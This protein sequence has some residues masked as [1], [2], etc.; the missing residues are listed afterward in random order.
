MFTLTIAKSIPASSM[1][2]LLVQVD[3]VGD[4]RVGDARRVGDKLAPI[5]G[6]DLRKLFP[7]PERIRK[8]GRQE[9]RVH[10]DSQARAHLDRPLAGRR[11][12][13][14]RAFRAFM[15]RLSLSYD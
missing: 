4:K 12:G 11:I 1:R 13:V 5:A 2:E 8:R 7:F 3:H 14:A 9:V 15:A 10:V 6:D